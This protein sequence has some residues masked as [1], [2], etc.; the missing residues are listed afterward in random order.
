MV[1][2]ATL[3]WFK[4]F[5]ENLNKDPVFS[6]SDFTSTWKYIFTDLM[7]DVGLPRTFIITFDKGQ[8]TEV[9][10]GTPEDEAEFT[11]EATYEVWC[12][13]VKDELD[14]TAAMMTGRFN[15]KG[16]T[17]KATTYGKELG[18]VPIITKSLSPVEY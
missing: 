5:Q 16:P 10:E 11:Y 6:K 12:K 7:T 14:I 9:R 3:A 8:I 13:I 17:G 15:M 1:K 18:R 4:L 2:Y